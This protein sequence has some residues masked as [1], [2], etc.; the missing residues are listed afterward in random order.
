MSA[1]SAGAA[2]RAARRYSWAKFFMVLGCDGG[3]ASSIKDFGTDNGESRER[4]EL[5]EG[6]ICD[7]SITPPGGR[8]RGPP[9]ETTYLC[10]TLASRDMAPIVVQEMG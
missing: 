7:I 9:R 2:V 8:V 10:S 1:A 5:E 4:R 6:R 3:L